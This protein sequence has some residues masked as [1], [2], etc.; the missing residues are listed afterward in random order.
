MALAAPCCPV[1]TRPLLSSIVTGCWALE[2]FFLQLFNRLV[3]QME[4]ELEGPIGTRPGAGAWQGPDPAPRKSPWLTL[5]CPLRR[6]A[7]SVGMGKAV[8]AYLY[9]RWLTKESR[10]SWEPWHS[11]ARFHRRSGNARAWTDGTQR[12]IR[13]EAHHD[14]HQER[15]KH[16]KARP[17]RRRKRRSA[18][19]GIAARPN[20]P[21]KLSSRLSRTWGCLMTSWPRSQGACEANSSCWV[22]SW[23]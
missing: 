20:T 7:D 4:L 17:R 21:P 22:K 15:Q 5:P 23:G 16:A 3:I 8:R 2:E 11:G 18:S 19:H 9:R 1:H 14:L 10:N 13:Q 12:S 6:A